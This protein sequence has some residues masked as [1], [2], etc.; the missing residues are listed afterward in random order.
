MRK[1]KGETLL[2]STQP[3][4]GGRGLPRGFIRSA[5]P[6]VH[7]GQMGA[8]AVKI[9]GWGKGIHDRAGAR[10]LLGRKRR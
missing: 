1:E 6:L 8:G 4:G 7:F 10:F 5:W 2:S 9:W 3:A